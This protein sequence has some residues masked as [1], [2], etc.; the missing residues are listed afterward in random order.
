MTWL[1]QYPSVLQE[2]ILVPAVP[3]FPS[4]LKIETAYSVT[5]IIVFALVV[6]FFSI[7]FGS[8]AFGLDIFLHS[9]H[10]S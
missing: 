3:K 5:N 6:L 10:L 2:N 8:L 1:S 4:L 7:Q 9:S